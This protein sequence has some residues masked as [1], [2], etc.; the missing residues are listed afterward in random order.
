MEGV[1]GNLR[2]KIWFGTCAICW[3]IWL[4]RNGVIFNNAQ[5]TT[6]LQLVFRGNV[7]DEGVGNTAKGRRRTTNKVGMTSA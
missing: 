4:C 3:A 5:V 6:P 7:L 1:E 2:N